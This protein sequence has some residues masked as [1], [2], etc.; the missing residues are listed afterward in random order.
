MK[1]LGAPSIFTPLALAA[2]L[3]RA[4]AA[5]TVAAQTPSPAQHRAFMQKCL[6]NVH[7][8]KADNRADFLTYLMRDET[9]LSTPQKLALLLS[10]LPTPATP[11]DSSFESTVVGC[12]GNLGPIAGAAEP[13]LMKLAADAGQDSYLRQTAVDALGLIGAQTPGVVT[14]LVPLIGDPKADPYRTAVPTA[15]E[16]LGPAARPAIPALAK[17]LSDDDT[18]FSLAIYTAMGR[19]ALGHAAPLRTTSQLR[20]HSGSGQDTAYIAA[21]IASLKRLHQLPPEQAAAAFLALQDAGR[22]AVAAVPVLIEI[23]KGQVEGQIGPSAPY[24]RAAAL[25]TLGSVGPG[26][27]AEAT[28][29][30]LRAAAYHS[31]GS[32]SAIADAGR[33]AL[34][35]VGPADHEAVGPLVEALK[36]AI[37]D[38]HKESYAIL[39]G[40]I[41]AAAAS[42]RPALL[43]LLNV[44]A[45]VP[46]TDAPLLP[47]VA[48]I[49][50]ARIGA[51]ARADADPAF[52]P[53]MQQQVEQAVLAE[54]RSDK[55]DVFANGTRAVPALGANW[56][57]AMPLLLRALDVGSPNGFLLAMKGFVTFGEGVNTSTQI[58]AIRAL[59]RLGPDAAAAIP[60]LTA[61][62]AHTTPSRNY[63]PRAD[64]EARKALAS[65]RGPQKVL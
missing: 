32:S 14:T 2:A 44:G 65:I 31:G 3:C 56:R 48:L 64:E 57:Q 10:L 54:L 61:I 36:T 41:G 38:Q 45:P 49:A 53:E 6:D 26:A 55:A 20:G 33:A 35:D 42:A 58:E 30:L 63:M 7:D 52:T 51:P 16:R 5:P 62:A 28:R 8:P 43:A 40:Q 60:A 18:S 15:L 1:S 59:G 50:L 34:E 9:F 39:L 24:V 27:S 37:N 46:N 13:Q 19:I 22:A 23:V 17:A 11:T 29:T 21:Q 47:Q 12:L 4:G 25:D